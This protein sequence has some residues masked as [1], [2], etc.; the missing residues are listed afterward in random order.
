MKAVIKTKRSETVDRYEAEHFE[1]LA[2]R[3]AKP[4][5]AKY[6]ERCIREGS[7]LNWI[8]KK[9]IVDLIIEKMVLTASVKVTNKELD[10]LFA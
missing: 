3:L 2:W 1:S 9:R 8:G 4:I 7:P 5:M 6:A 10:S